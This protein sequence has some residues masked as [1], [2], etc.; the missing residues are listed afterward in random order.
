MAVLEA[1][2]SPVVKVAQGGGGNP[3]GDGDE[4]GPEG[5][6]GVGKPDDGLEGLCCDGVFGLGK[7]WGS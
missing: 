4:G 3:W 5:E 1:M 2:V 6:G 7:F